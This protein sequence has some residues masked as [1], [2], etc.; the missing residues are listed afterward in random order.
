MYCTARAASLIAFACCVLPVAAAMLCGSAD[1][2]VKYISIN[3]AITKVYV[4][5][6]TRELL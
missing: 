3:A 5:C 2:T 6:G 1:E 4:H